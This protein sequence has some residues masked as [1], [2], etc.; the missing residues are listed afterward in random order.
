MQFNYKLLLP[1]FATAL[2]ALPSSGNYLV[3]ITP[4]SESVWQANTTQRISWVKN[5]AANYSKLSLKLG[6]GQGKFSFFSNFLKN[7]KK[8]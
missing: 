2:Q 3:G 8:I 5:P 7:K 1:L 6:H 4:W